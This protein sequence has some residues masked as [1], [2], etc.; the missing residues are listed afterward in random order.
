M[1]TRR[2]PGFAA[3]PGLLRELHAL[4]TN[5]VIT[6]EAEDL[7]HHF[8]ARVIAPVFGFV[9]NPLDLQRGDALGGIGRNGPFQIDE[10]T[11]A[12]DLL[13]QRGRRHVQRARERLQLLRRRIDLVRPR[14]NRLHRRADRQRFAEAIDDASAMRRAPRCRGC[15]ASCPAPAETRCRS[16][17]GRAIGPEAAGTA[18]A[19]RRTRAARAIAGRRGGA[20]AAS[21]IA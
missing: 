13:F 18:R 21:L 1:I 6:G 4:L 17:A 15:S 14:P 9:V 19:A 3:Q 8:A 5:I 20:A 16:A 7:A 11:A 2:L 12:G 10:I